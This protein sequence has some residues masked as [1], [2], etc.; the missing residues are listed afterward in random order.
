[1]RLS[2]IKDK[3]KLVSFQELID[4]DIEDFYTSDGVPKITW[5]KGINIENTTP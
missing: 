4:V 2:K 3:L 5:M 1:M